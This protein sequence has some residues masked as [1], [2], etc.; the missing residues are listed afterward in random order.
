[1][2]TQSYSSYEITPKQLALELLLLGR[3]PAT[4]IYLSFDEL[5]WIA[6]ITTIGALLY[7]VYHTPKQP[8]PL[9]QYDLQ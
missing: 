7:Y 2:F 1:M 4:N 5:I 9:L 8:E 6:G 3:V